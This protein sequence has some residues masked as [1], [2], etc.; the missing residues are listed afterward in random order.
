MSKTTKTLAKE[1][2]LTIFDDLS[3]EKVTELLDFAEFLLFK[4]EKTDLVAKSGNNPILEIIGLADVEPF[5]D[6]ID[7]ELYG[8][9]SGLDYV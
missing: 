3:D 6:R 7:D 1:T 5:A 8:E 9:V 4:T 2:L